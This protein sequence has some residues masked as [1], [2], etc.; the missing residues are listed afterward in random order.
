MRSGSFFPFPQLPWAGAIVVTSLLSGVY[1]S[2][3]NGQGWPV[4]DGKYCI[5]QPP[6]NRIIPLLPGAHLTDTLQAGYNFRCASP[7]TDSEVSANYELSGFP[8]SRGIVEFNPSKC[9]GKWIPRSVSGQA[10]RPGALC[11]VYSSISETLAIDEN[12]ILSGKVE[13]RCVSDVLPDTAP[14]AV[15]TYDTSVSYLLSLETSDWQGSY[16]SAASTISDQYPC[17]PLFHSWLQ[18][19]WAL[20]GDLAQLQLF[21]CGPPECERMLI[22][23]IDPSDLKSWPLANQSQREWLQRELANSTASV[24]AIAAD[25]TSRA[26]IVIESG[27]PRPLTLRLCQGTCPTSPSQVDPNSGSL[28][29]LDSGFSPSDP[30]SLPLDG[31]ASVILSPHA[32]EGLPLGR[33]FAFAVFTPPAQINSV[34][35][36]VGLGVYG[37]E[38][39]RENL[40][41]LLELPPVVLVHGLWGTPDTWAK[42]KRLISAEHQSVVLADYSKTSADTYS[43][44][45][46]QKSFRCAIRQALA[47]AHRDG[48]VATRVDVVAHSMGGLVARAYARRPAYRTAANYMQGEINRLVTIGTPHAGTELADWLLAHIDIPVN[49]DSII[50]DLFSCEECG[51]ITLREFMSDVLHRSIGTGISALSVAGI[52][53][54]TDLAGPEDLSFSSVSGIAV[55][56][57]SVQEML[58]L[59]IES[60]DGYVGY[61]GHDSLDSIFH[62]DNDTIVNSAS[63]ASGAVRNIDAA[64]IVHASPFPW[65]ATETNGEAFE[66]LKMLL[67]GVPPL[68][69]SA[70]SS[71]RRIDK[72]EILDVKSGYPSLATLG[73]ASSDSVSLTPPDGASLAALSPVTVSAFAAGKSVTRL[74]V[75][76]DEKLVDLAEA[77]F[78]WV[79]TPLR[80]GVFEARL[81]V[82]FDDDTYAIKIAN[83][84]VVPPP[85]LVA[86]VAEPNALF[87]SG[88]GAKLFLQ[89]QALF[90]SG[91]Y[92]VRELASY[93]VASGGAKVASV[94]TDG[95][96]TALAF[97]TATVFIYYLDKTIV[98]PV[99]VGGK[100]LKGFF[101]VDRCQALDTRIPGGPRGGPPLRAGRVR[102]LGLT[103]ICRIPKDAIA[104]TANITVVGASGKGQ[105]FLFPSDQER[106]QLSLISWPQSTRISDKVLPLARDSSGTVAAVFFGS[107]TFDLVVEITGY[108]R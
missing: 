18:G 96:V 60:F 76:L 40:N 35:R 69:S 100:D 108:Y 12:G 31:G 86:L 27:D 58:N 53:R 21:Y 30:S 103:G 71:T 17:A 97:G 26:L 68:V 47:E 87:L 99:Y 72:A 93:T 1:P 37:D 106:P 56:G 94:S 11:G 95:E 84:K 42:F 6:L 23:I 91:S 67:G 44:P 90:G 85:T 54:A 62:A 13:D 34:R 51:P 28:N 83:Y 74:S 16:R 105:L 52:R 55:G 63:Q 32:V 33:Y 7:P 39:L 14:G 20:P 78:G 2:Q 101:E 10:S 15:R 46:T 104:V 77:P 29:Q 98:V 79:W 5:T 89:A 3:A 4:P 49:E 48:V 81:A 66:K 65:D 38:T 102:V 59:I 41:F 45:G 43:D 82:I 70:M 19:D 24:T 57:S 8:Y 80:P 73:R 75:L 92:G 107:G 36:L 25:G 88:P 9:D 61:A 22:H 64:G 50:A